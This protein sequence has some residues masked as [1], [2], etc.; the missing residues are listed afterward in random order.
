MDL[1]VKKNPS[2]KEMIEQAK[3]REHVEWLQNK[4]TC[5]S[6]STQK[7]ERRAT[8]KSVVKYRQKK[9]WNELCNISDE[10]YI[11]GVITGLPVQRAE[12]TIATEPIVVRL[13]G[14]NLEQRSEALKPFITKVRYNVVQNKVT[15]AMITE[16]ETTP[17]NRIR[18]LPFPKYGA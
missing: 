4:I 13:S 6:S 2:L 17:E 7:T 18:E 11:S 12:G 8:T 10:K 15:Q 1:A 5:Q 14:M 9:T 16:T 3:A